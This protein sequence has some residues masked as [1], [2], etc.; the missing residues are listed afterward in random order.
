MLEIIYTSLALTCN[1]PL[2]TLIASYYLYFFPVLILLC[3]YP[4]TQVILTNCISLQ[5]HNLGHH[6]VPLYWHYVMCLRPY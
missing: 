4:G 5:G 1:N 2:S 6:P 3:T